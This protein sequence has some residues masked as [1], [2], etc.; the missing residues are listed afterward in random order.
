MKLSLFSVSYAGLWGQAELDLPEFIA[1]A[2]NWDT[3]R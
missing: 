3:T 1:K 2:R